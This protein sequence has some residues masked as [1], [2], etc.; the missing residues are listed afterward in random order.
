YYSDYVIAGVSVD[1]SVCD[2]APSKVGTLVDEIKNL[3]TILIKSLS[4]PIIREAVILAHWRAQSYKFDQYT[5]LWDF[6]DQL[7]EGCKLFKRAGVMLKNGEG[8]FETIIKACQE[9]KKTIS[10]ENRG[11]VLKSCYSGPAVQFSHGLSIYFPWNEG[12]YDESYK[13]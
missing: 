8:Q 9:V 2:L 1:Q 4:N 3:S 5:D 12:T 6:C 13:N 7:M 11:L 10:A